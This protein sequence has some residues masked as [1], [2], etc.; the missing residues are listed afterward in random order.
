MAGFSD[1]VRALSWRN[2]AHAQVGADARA[3]GV[4]RARRGSSAI[5][6]H[7]ERGIRAAQSVWRSVRADSS[8]C[9]RASRRPQAYRDRDRRDA[10]EPRPPLRLSE[11]SRIQGAAN[12]GPDRYRLD[13]A[14]RYPPDSARLRWI[15]ARRPPPPGP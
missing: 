5:E 13:P 6:E 10:V 4:A 1:S 2:D 7:Q 3:A 9:G 11:R 14:G 12:A 15:A 8:G